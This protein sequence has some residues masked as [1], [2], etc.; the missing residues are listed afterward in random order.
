MK[1]KI[2]TL[3]GTIDKT[4]FDKKSTY[5]VGEPKV[6]EILQAMHVNFEYEYESLMRKDSLDMCEEDRELLFERVRC[7]PHR[8]IL[9]THGTDTMIESARKLQ[10]VRDKVIVFTGAFW[11]A[12]FK[13]SDAEFNV[14][15]AVAALQ[16]LPEGV[17]IAING[18]VFHA[19]RV[20]KN[21]ERTHFED[22]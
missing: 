11:P 13:S 8:L 22:A 7:D 5:Q 9:V 6:V 3:G 2:F 16:T 4:Y 18:R 19:D 12:G 21:R 15:S 1:I 10:T 17:Y 14:G 20:R